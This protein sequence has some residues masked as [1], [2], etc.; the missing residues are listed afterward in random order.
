LP[1][2]AGL[3]RM[4]QANE[5]Q[6]TMATP[7]RILVVED[8]P[9]DTLLLQRAFASAPS[10]VPIHYVQDGQ[11]AIDFLKAQ[12]PFDNPIEQPLPTL[13]L[14]DLKM[15]RM[16]GFDVLE[17]L[18]RQPGQNRIVAV[19]FSSS[20]QREDIN[21]AYALGAR[22]YFVKPADPSQFID[23]VRQLQAYW[24]EHNVLPGD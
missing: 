18:W 7:L 5:C 19:V 24:L 4:L 9:D 20:N 6:R 11:E 21:R 12:P 16:D 14:L 17:W 13:V 2:L 1:R 22:S 10:H 3:G 15:P 8:D 23:I